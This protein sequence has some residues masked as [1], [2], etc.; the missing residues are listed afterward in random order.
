MRLVLGWVA[1]LNS[2]LGSFA[3]SERAQCPV[4]GASIGPWWLPLCTLVTWGL[5]WCISY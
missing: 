3:I 4:C 1:P 2:S 5:A